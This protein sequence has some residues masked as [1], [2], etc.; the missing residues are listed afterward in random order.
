MGV[1]LNLII[2]FIIFISF[3]I[4]PI[5]AVRSWLKL[6]PSFTKYILLSISLILGVVS[7]IGIYQGLSGQPWDLLFT[8]PFFFLIFA[9]HIGG[10][11]LTNLLSIKPIYLFLTGAFYTSI[12]YFMLLLALKITRRFIKL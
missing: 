11:N 5:L 6:S 2:F 8:F 9:Q 4:L 3:F 10:S 12:T 1:G 7:S